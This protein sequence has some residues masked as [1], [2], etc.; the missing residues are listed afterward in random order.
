MSKK[1][2]QNK[3]PKFKTTRDELVLELQA[4]TMVPIVADVIER[5]IKPVVESVSPELRAAVQDSVV[6]A[7]SRFNIAMVESSKRVY[8]RSNFLQ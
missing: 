4:L 1:S 2:K 5:H 3:K 8:G 7:V 6:E